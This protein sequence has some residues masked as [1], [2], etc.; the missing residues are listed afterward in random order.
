MGSES[1]IINCFFGVRESL[2]RWMMD[3]TCTY[4]KMHIRFVLLGL[5]GTGYPRPSGTIPVIPRCKVTVFSFMICVL[6]GGLFGEDA[7]AALPFSALSFVRER[8]H[9]ENQGLLSL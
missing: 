7:S 9:H 5:E 8:P 4:M 1:T 2:V 3:V 6:L